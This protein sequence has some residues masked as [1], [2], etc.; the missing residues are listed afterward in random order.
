M[1]NRWG[2]F[3][4]AMLFVPVCAAA[5]TRTLAGTVVDDSGAALPG[6]VVVVTPAGGGNPRETVTDAAG[7]FA[8]PN[9]ESGAARLRADL[10][11]FQATEMNVKV[12]ADGKTDV[13]VKMKVGF[14]EEV[15][16][17]ADAAAG[18]LSPG[19]NA[20]A[21][22]F[23]PEALRRLPTEAQDLQTLVES[24]AAGAPGGVSV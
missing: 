23:D 19:R 3:L 7:H 13:T 1:T 21:V 11:G 8:F 6:A 22:E 14:D 15:T 16:V 10:A 9:V 18:V 5:Q 4:I 20:N 2:W 17:S 24:F 12:A